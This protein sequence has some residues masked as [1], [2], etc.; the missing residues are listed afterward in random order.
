MVASLWNAFQPR[1]LP[2]VIGNG[3]GATPEHAAI[4]RLAKYGRS[5][6]LVV[7]NGRIVLDDEEPM[8]ADPREVAKLM[9]GIA[10]ELCRTSIFLRYFPMI[11]P[12]GRRTGW[13]V[14]RLDR[15]ARPHGNCADW[16]MESAGFVPGRV[17]KLAFVRD[18]LASRREGNQSQTF[19]NR[20]WK[21]HD[22]IVG[23][24]RG[25]FWE[26][27]K[28]PQAMAC[29]GELTEVAR[30]LC[31]MAWE[32]GEEAGRAPARLPDL[33]PILRG[34]FPSLLRPG[35]VANRCLA[36]LLNASEPMSVNALAGAGSGERPS[37]GGARRNVKT[38]LAA[39]AAEGLAAQIP[40][41][42]V[43]GPAA[44]Q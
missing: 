29:G 25:V 9:E 2:P 11:H 15:S 43:R 3:I 12:D 18:W 44:E 21:P 39:L 36:E 38:A 5:G 16:A 14:A 37:S 6:G 10:V 42:W 27:K 28:W 7:R 30:L 34:R 20:I 17:R 24:L 13:D 26:G 19:E 31:L 33:L 4:V 22:G 8:T 35:S 41:G 32:I 23:S 1:D 40:T